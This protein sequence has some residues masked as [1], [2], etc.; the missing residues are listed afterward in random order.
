MK[1]SPPDREKYE[2]A[3]RRTEEVAWG[4]L[5]TAL[6]W[7]FLMAAV[8][9]PTMSLSLRI[10]AAFALLAAELRLGQR[11]ALLVYLST[12]LL[13]LIYPGFLLN[14]PWTLYFAPYLLLAFFFSRF[15]SGTTC[16]LLRLA[17]GTGLFS[18]LAAFYGPALFPPSLRTRLQP[19]F[20]LIVIAL[21]LIGSAIYDALLAYLS[22]FY[23]S[24]L[25]HSTRPEKGDL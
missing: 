23:T 18:A 13:T 7:L 9:L 24:R 8:W 3:R 16:I 10:L 4:G 21:G 25:A 15:F 11:A 22:A 20:W 14:L 2:L 19:H 5:F 12:T 6:C 17:A 1:K